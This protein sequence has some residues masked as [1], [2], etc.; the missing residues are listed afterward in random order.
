MTRIVWPVLAVTLVSTTIGPSRNATLTLPARL[1]HYLTKSV[2]LNA[3]QRRALV[4][5]AAVT[6]LLEADENKE[7][8]EVEDGALAALQSTKRRLE[9]SR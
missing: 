2:K 4:E 3:H 7:V 6:K 1:D 5:G 8:S 9:A